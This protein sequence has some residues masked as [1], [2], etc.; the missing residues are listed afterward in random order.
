MERHQVYDLVDLPPG[1][2]AIGC[3]SVFTVKTDKDGNVT[4]YKARL[5]LLGYQ[6]RPGI[7]F[8]EL[9]SPVARFETIRG[10]LAIAAKEQLYLHQLDVKSAFLT[11][12]L[13]EELYMKQPDGFD[14]G[15]GRVWRLRKAL[16]GNVHAPRAF[17]Q[18]MNKTLMSMETVKLRQSSADPCL[19]FS[20]SPRRLVVLVFVDDAMIAGIDEELGTFLLGGPREK[21]PKW[22]FDLL[23]NERVANQ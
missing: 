11:A 10:A 16:Y 20:E 7:D 1:R 6:Q 14:D 17:N 13:Q 3:Q 2:R 19:Y 21:A 23:A 5:V 9:F 15:S 22:C 12:D 8:K 4:R 18:K